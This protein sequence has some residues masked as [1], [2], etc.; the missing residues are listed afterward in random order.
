MTYKF[1]QFTNEI[2]PETIEIMDEILLNRV[3]GTYHVTVKF[4]PSDQA[5]YFMLPFIGL[6]EINQQVVDELKKYE[7]R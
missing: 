1:E 3:K 7:T 2:T 5:V 6:N 4:M